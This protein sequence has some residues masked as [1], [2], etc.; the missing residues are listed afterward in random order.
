MPLRRDPAPLVDALRTTPWTLLHGD[1]KLGNLGTAADG[2]TI[3]IDWA[4]PGAGPVGHELAWYLALN[5]ARL[6]AGH[7]KETTIADFRAALER[8]GVATAGWWDRQL[9]LCLLGALVQFGWEK[10][11][12]DR[13]RAGLVVRPGDG[14][15]AP[16]VTAGATPAPR[17]RRRLRRHRRVVERGPVGVYNHLAD[18]VV[19]RQPG[20]RGRADRCS[21]SAPAPA[22]RAGDR[23]ARAAAPSPSTPRWACS[24][25]G[26]SSRPPAAVAD[27]LA[28]PL[29]DRSVGG[30]VAAFSLNHLARPAAALAEA[31]RVCQPGSPIVAAT[32]AEDDGHPVK[33]A[34]LAALVAHGWEPPAWYRALQQDVAPLLWST[35][36]ARDVCAE[37][38]LDAEIERRRVALPWLGPGDLVDWRLGMAQH[39]P[40]VDQLPSSDRAALRAAAIDELGA[41]PP[42]LERSILVIVAVT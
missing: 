25:T 6:P 26:V 13:R 7:T 17:H 37:A 27:A 20:A 29:P 42:P 30:V 21:T 31:R 11:L 5:R 36:S 39:A 8:H 1:W 38:G 18:V 24:P 9:D 28:L 22:R 19:D 3:L 16:I 34:V 14:G 12:G 2:R 23:P 10:A 33:A 40:F 41:D 35:A 15:R 32:Y 4:Y